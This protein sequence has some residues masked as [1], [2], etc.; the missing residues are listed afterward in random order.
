MFASGGRGEGEG[1]FGLGAVE[2]GL[3]LGLADG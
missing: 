1:L 3:L 2:L